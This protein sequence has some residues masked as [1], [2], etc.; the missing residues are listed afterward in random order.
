MPPLN[1]PGI[2]LL[3]WHC[4]VTAI[5]CSLMEDTASLFWLNLTFNF[6]EWQQLSLTELE[7]LSSERLSV[8]DYLFENLFPRCTVFLN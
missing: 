6:G 8:K 4:Y 7:R 1:M 2:K 3:L 5:E